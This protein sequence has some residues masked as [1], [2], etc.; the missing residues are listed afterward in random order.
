MANDSLSDARTELEKE[1]T[2]VRKHFGDIESAMRSVLDADADDDIEH[3]LAEL[4]DKV[5]KA[6]TG[7]VLG[8]GANSH[9]RAR[10]KYLELSGKK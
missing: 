8:S 1:Y 2:D 10:K 4:E 7:G 9:A 5:K 3:L 6:R